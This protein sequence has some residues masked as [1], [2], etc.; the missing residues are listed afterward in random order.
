MTPGRR[1]T[2]EMVVRWRE[3][4]HEV[5]QTRKVIV[6]VGAHVAVEF[7]VVDNTKQ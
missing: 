3:K 1:Y 7:P 6:T 2:Y 5:R 4:D